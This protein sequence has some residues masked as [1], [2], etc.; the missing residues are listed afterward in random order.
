MQKQFKPC[1]V[2]KVRI[3]KGEEALYHNR[4]LRSLVNEQKDLN[5]V[6]VEEIGIGIFAAIAR[7]VAWFA[8][9]I[10]FQAICWGIGWVVLK[11]ITFGKYPNKDSN[12]EIVCAVGLFLLVTSAVIVTIYTN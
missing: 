9:E 2:I 10:F 5:I 8:I 12:H 4:L 3:K 6:P 7:F 11:T 1:T